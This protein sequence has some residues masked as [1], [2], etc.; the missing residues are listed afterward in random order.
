MKIEKLYNSNVYR[1]FESIY[2]FVI[3]NF[4]FIL[5]FVLGLGVFSFFLALIILVLAIKSFDE[6]KDSIIKTWINMVMKYGF[7]AFRYSLVFVIIILLFIFNSVY[8]FLVLEEAIHWVYSVMFSFSLACLLISIAALI[9]GAFV[10]VYYPNLSFK[11]WLKYSFMLL[12]IFPLQ[13]LYLVGSIVLSV[14][15]LYT[16]PLILILILPSLS[17]YIYHLITKKTYKRLV[18]EGVET[19]KFQIDPIKQLGGPN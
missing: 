3:F 1:L 11:K 15:L 10:F 8:F 16:A 9:N 18:A 19:L 13:T 2:R 4:L 17:L 6:S 14:F 7:K 12:R 5:T